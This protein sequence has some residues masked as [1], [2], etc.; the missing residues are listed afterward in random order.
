[1]MVVMLRALVVVVAALGMTAASAAAQTK[2]PT[3]KPTAPT[4]APPP[5]CGV[6]GK[7]P[8][9]IN[10]TGATQGYNGLYVALSADASIR[11]CPRPE[12]GTG[13][14]PSTRGR[15]ARPQ[16]RP[17]PSRARLPRPPSGM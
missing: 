4:P 13:R 7:L 14:S 8:Q 10:G 9:V 3:R 17:T 12:T 2:S 6:Y 1:M 16:R 15:W 11:R 5:L